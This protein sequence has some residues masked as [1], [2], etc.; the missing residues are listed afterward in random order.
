M[1]NKYKQK[2]FA[3]FLAGVANEKEHND[4]LKLPEVKQMMS[5]Q[6]SQK[7]ADYKDIAKP[8]LYALLAKVYSKIMTRQQQVVKPRTKR[9]PL[10]QRIAAVAALLVL[11]LTAGTILWSEGLI[12]GSNLV[13]INAPEGVKAEVFLPDGSRVWLNSGSK[14][15]YNKK[16]DSKT[17]SLKLAGEAYFN[18][19]H[20]PSRPLVVKTRK[21]DVEVLGTRFNIIS[22]PSEERWEATL[23][24]GSIR[25]NPLQKGLSK[26]LSLIPG[27]KAVWIISQ[28]DFS[29]ETVNTLNITR[30]VSNQ[31]TFEDEPFA[32]IARQ[33]ELTFG[34]K[35]EIPRELAERYR[36]TAKF[37][38]ESI[39]EIFKLLQIT[40]PFD[41][42]MQGNKVVVFAK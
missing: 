31:L 41:F 39:Y 25:V 11:L 13:T 17:R 30:W 10:Y 42:K 8:E 33:L 38:D 7:N 5:E 22:I 2:L 40:A 12:P 34:V 20:D 37:T 36:F 35:I 32:L 16:F 28:N 1:E 26:S 29:I 23:V 15:T 24:S 9:I 4:I 6:W 27:Q 21:A 14:L 18:I 3:R 19:S